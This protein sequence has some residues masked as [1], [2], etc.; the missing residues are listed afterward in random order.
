MS[1]L[2]N[3]TINFSDKLK[4]IWFT[5][6]R[7]ATR[8]SQHIQKYLNFNVTGMHGVN[9]P[10]GK[11][12]YFFIHNVRNPYSRLVSIYRLFKQYHKIE[13]NEF[14][15]WA[16]KKLKEERDS[17]VVFTYDYQIY[18]SKYQFYFPKK[19]D[20][21]IRFENLES[22]IRNLWFI[23]ENNSDEL[24]KVL[25]ENIV[26]NNFKTECGDENN[27]RE[28]YDDELKEYVYHHLKEDFE[29]FN[30]SKEF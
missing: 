3:T 22:D 6:P 8:S 21:I 11:K 30:Y 15:L 2:T 28:Q 25:Q 27:W 26:F 29:L 4:V 12:D 16:T 5:P 20:Y 1:I 9:I 24:E 14:K 13:K 18:L 23:K 17:S 7:T 10:K 19:P